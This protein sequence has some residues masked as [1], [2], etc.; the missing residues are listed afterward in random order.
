MSS[1]LVAY[2]RSSFQKT[3]KH[4]PT[5]EAEQNP[6]ENP[7]TGVRRTLSIH[8][9]SKDVIVRHRE[10]IFLLLWISRPAAAKL[11]LRACLKIK[12]CRS[13]LPSAKEYS[14]H[15]RPSRFLPIKSLTF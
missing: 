4:M 8:H 14:T 6:K 3:H 12:N 9:L 10:I 11:C 1:P 13:L 15:R 7:L 5:L 2:G